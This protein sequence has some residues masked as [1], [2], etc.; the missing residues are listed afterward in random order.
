MAWIEETWAPVVLSSFAGSSRGFVVHDTEVEWLASTR[1]FMSAASDKANLGLRV[2][3]AIAMTAPLWMSLR[4]RTLR[5]LTP[6]ERSRVMERLLVHPIFFVR[7]LTLLLKLV[8]CMAIFRSA[9]ARARTDYDRP[10]VEA[11]GTRKRALAIV[12]AS[13]PPSFAEEVA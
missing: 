12:P 7:E 1:R 11:T 3:F 13:A 6:E 8:A 2:A 10:L 4:F 5:G 9:A